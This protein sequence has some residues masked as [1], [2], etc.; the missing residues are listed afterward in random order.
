MGTVVFRLIFQH[1]LTYAIELTMAD[2]TR[3]LIKSFTREAEAEAWIAKQQRR[4]PKDEVWIRRPLRSW[5]T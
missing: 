2:G 5:R 3:K 1:D 4:A